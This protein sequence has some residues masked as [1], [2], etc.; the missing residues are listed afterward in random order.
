MQRSIIICFCLLGLA[1]SGQNRSTAPKVREVVKKFYSQ[2]TMDILTYPFVSFEKRKEGWYVITQQVNNHDLEPVDRFL[3]YDNVS[4]RYKPLSFAKV[5]PSKEV[6]PADYFDDYTLKNYDLHIYYGYRGWYKDV[7][8]DLKDRKQLSDDEMNSLARAYSMYAGALLSDQA[9]D[10]VLSEVWQLPLKMNCLSPQQIMQFN[11]LE[12][13]AQEYF[14]KLADRNPQYETTVGKIGMKYANEFMFQFA[15]LLA[16]AN[17]YAVNIKLPGNLYTAEQ[18]KV[19]QQNLENC[20]LN[21]ILFSFGDNDYYPVLYLQ[22]AKSIRRDVY[23]VNYS[24]I[25]MDRYVY[26]ATQPQFEAAGLK[27]SV[28]TT[29]YAG[30]ANNYVIVNHSRD[31]LYFDQFLKLIKPHNEDAETISAAYIAIPVKQH[32]DIS[33]TTHIDL[34]T[35]NYLLKNNWVLLDMINNLNGRK[36]CFPNNFDGDPL[37]DLNNYLVTKEGLYIYAN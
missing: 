19:A 25:G 34:K 24:L 2:Y 11:A 7:I 29:C 36:I 28:D 10:A 18:L 23:L 27:L 6:K 30:N 5:T 13:K 32:G 17:D 14:K 33:I 8:K 1:V 20:P 16:Y 12:G 9:S 37:Q 26:R 3:F 22:Q 4:K 35:T 21:A 15:L 31:T